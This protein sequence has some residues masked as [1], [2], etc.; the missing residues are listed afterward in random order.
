MSFSAALPSRFCQRRCSVLN[1]CYLNVGDLLKKML[2]VVFSYMIRKYLGSASL[3]IASYIFRHTHL[4]L[5][6]LISTITCTC[7]N[8]ILNCCRCSTN[9][10]RCGS[11][12]GPE[13][14]GWRGATSAQ[15]HHPFLLLHRST[16]DCEY[17]SVPCWCW[18]V[19]LWLQWG[20]TLRGWIVCMLAN[21]FFLWAECYLCSASLLH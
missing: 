15:P 20:Y 4:Y 9:K 13:R 2:P 16:L 6:A 19:L 11:Q 17:N 7:E 12:A 10:S 5:H 3:V 1:W 18:H 14:A 8:R 21:G